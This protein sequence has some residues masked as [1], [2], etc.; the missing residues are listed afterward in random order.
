[1]E[2]ENNELNSASEGGEMEQVDSK[3]RLQKVL[4]TGLAYGVGLVVASVVAQLLFWLIERGWKEIS[5]TPRDLILGLLVVVIVQLFVGGI[6]GFIGGWTLP[7]IGRERGKYGYA[8]RSAITFGLV[9]GTLLFILVLLISLM[10]MTDAPFQEP[11][12][13]AT[14]FMFLGVIVGALYSLLLGLATVGLR[15][16]GWVLLGGFLGFGLGG[17]GFGY[18][19]WAYLSAAPV[20]EVA[21][22]PHL[23]LILGLAVFGFLGG[24]GLSWAYTQLAKRDEV[25]P[26]SLGWRLAGIGILAIVLVLIINAI[27]PLLG[28]AAQVL[29][30][31]EAKFSSSIEMN[32]AGTHWAEGVFE[33]AQE[34]L[35]GFDVAATQANQV[36][37]A[38][39]E[40]EG[41]G[42]DLYLQLGRVDPGTRALKWSDSVNLSGSEA[43]IGEPQIAADSSGNLYVV[44][45]E[46][47]NGG[48]GLFYSSCAAGECSEPSAL[49]STAALCGT[50]EASASQTGYPI[51][52]A[53][54][55]AGT[56]MVV[57]GDG[58]GGLGYL[59]FSVGEPQSATG[60]CVPL[61]DGVGAGNFS[62]EDQAGDRFALGFDDGA[63]PGGQ[64][65]LANYG[66]AAWETAPEQIGQGKN[67]SIFVGNA[68]GL[69]SAWCLP[70]TGVQFWS[71]GQEE[72]VSELTCLGTP[73]VAEDEFGQ[74]H[75]VWFS[76]QVQDVLG[77]LQTEKVLYE[78]I[79]GENGWTEP[80]IVA[81]PADPA[82]YALT[83]DEAGLLYLGW[84]DEE[85]DTTR[86]QFAFQ[87]Q[88]ACDPAELSGIAKIS[89]E[90]TQREGYRPVDD[91]VP[92][93]N[94]RYE[95]MIY[96]PNAVPAFT[97]HPVT[98]NGGYDDYVDWL[99]TAEYEVLFATMAFKNAEN[100]D[101]PGSV[102]ADGVVEL[103]EMVKAN[104][105][106]YPRGMTVR[107]LL[108]NSPPIT[109]MEIDGQLWHMLKDLKEAGLEQMVDEELGFRVEV[110]NYSGAWPHSHVKT[111]IVDGKTAI[112]A[113]FNHEY[114]P[115]PKDHYSGKGMGDVDTGIVVTGPVAQHTHR[116]YDEIWEGAIQR[117][118]DLTQPMELWRFTC[119]DSRGVVDHSPEVM[120]YF[121]TESDA[122]AF[123]WFRTKVYD[124]SDKQIA[125]TFAAAD[126]SIDILQAQFAMPL[127]CN[128]NHFFDVCTFEQAPPYLQSLMTAAENGAKVR[129]LLTPFPIQSVENVLAMEIMNT[130]AANRGL[131][132]R[133]ELRLREDLLHAKTAF[134]DGEFLVIGS[135][136]LHYGA[137][138]EGDGLAEY[139]IAI[140]DPGAFDEYRRM[141]EYYW[142]E[143]SL[144][145]Q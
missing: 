57:Q 21:Q 8:W 89:Y 32:T 6:A 50:E 13:Y 138:T 46:G 20:G 137:Y 66:D 123:S 40:S 19:L 16:V 73:L 94:N 72:L 88:Y 133:M 52:I 130:E 115:L 22:G 112:A 141:F 4:T 64:V 30:P 145:P 82:N 47:V 25:K 31:R 7:V 134:L 102:L 51:D 79:R 65:W 54:S 122:T 1:M 53:A 126:E 26:L 45:Q 95:E 117:E 34:P 59:T 114:K 27:K 68:P 15:R 142:E 99:K 118:C 90:V 49:Q 76:D 24:V 62:L 119:E 74:L 140:V 78:S 36:G 71:D 135:Q 98:T 84:N 128:L 96:T 108:G 107:L 61:P 144:P 60:G 55:E 105:E 14:T 18:G 109:E 110:A 2:K 132:D 10:T 120:R 28:A 11:S 136:N 41:Q 38:W 80:A 125:E 127:I 106:K 77:Q 63:D 56:V 93:C 143:T 75:V 104:P 48:T 139:N 58:S 29:T 116:I 92:F 43:V 42:A 12:E 5:D 131:S 86:I 37:V 33:A 124:E 67:P 39:V 113:G 23:Y 81:Q 100:H 3:S 101:T 69:Q 44:W 111:M 91:L 121:P 9:Y 103:Y 85:A 87:S 35:G 70:E 129:I 17:F 83:N 97:D